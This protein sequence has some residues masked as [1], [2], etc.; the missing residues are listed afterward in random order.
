[1]WRVLPKN[2][3]KS[4]GSFKSLNQ[5]NN[6]IT[7]RSMHREERSRDQFITQIK[8]H[9]IKITKQSINSKQTYEER[10]ELQMGLEREC[11]CEL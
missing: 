10:E 6:I 2:D 7:A 8:S 4:K 5:L 9:V 11:V 1:M 3:A